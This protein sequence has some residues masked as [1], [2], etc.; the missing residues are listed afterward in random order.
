MDEFPF[1]TPFTSQLTP[2]LVVPET[3]A[4]NCCVWPVSKPALGGEIET[5]T[6]GGAIET[7]ALADAED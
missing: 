4:L 3:V 1:R 7:D 5:V 2:V 6:C